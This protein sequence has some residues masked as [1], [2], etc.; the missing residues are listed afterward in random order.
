MP[1]S[2]ILL[3]SLAGLTWN[4]IEAFFS[5]LAELKELEIEEE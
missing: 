3:V 2:L 1:K 5:K 4:R